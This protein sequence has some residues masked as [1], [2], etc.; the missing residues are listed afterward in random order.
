MNFRCFVVALMTAGW[1]AALCFAAPQDFASDSSGDEGEEQRPIPKSIVDDSLYVLPGFKA[2]VIYR[3]PPGE[4]SWVS[5]AVDDKGRL[6]TSTQYG[7][8]YRITLAADGA[9]ADV[10]RLDIEIGGIQGLVYAFDSLYAV[11]N[12]YRDD[13]SGLYRLRDTNGDDQYD[14]V[15]RLRVF[16]GDNEHGPHAVILSPDG[17]GLYVVAGNRSALPEPEKSKA[18]RNWADDGLLSYGRRYGEGIS[19]NRAGGWICRTDPDG[20][21]FEL[22]ASG[23]R[24]PYDIAFNAD[25]EMFT[26]DA[27]MEDDMGGLS[28]ITASRTP[29]LSMPSGRVWGAT[30]GTFVSPPAW[31]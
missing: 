20:K 25:G 24:N 6:I 15:K 31:H 10:Q 28:G 30:I 16:E 12:H 22:I 14:E 4:G 5:L 3:H 26:Y 2:D 7:G 27:D 21:T 17:K 9:V 1:A 23:L 8:L 18:A 19:E 13:S 11:V 29:R